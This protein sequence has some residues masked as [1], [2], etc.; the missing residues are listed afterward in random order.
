[1]DPQVY[2]RIAQGCM[3]ATVTSAPKELARSGDLVIIPHE[4]Y[5]E[6][7]QIR[8]SISKV[9]PTKEELRAISRG[10]KEFKEG[11]YVEWSQFRRELAHR[12]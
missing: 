4:E 7:L 6:F 8:K 10:R 5:E 9:K 12:N 1:L 11:K 2:D 3:M